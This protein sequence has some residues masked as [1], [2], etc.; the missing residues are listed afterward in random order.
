MRRFWRKQEG[1]TLVELMAVVAIIGVLAAIAVPVY[2]QATAR[3]NQRAVEANLRIIDGAIMMYQASGA[4]GAPTRTALEGTYITA[5][6]V[7]PDGVTY[8]I[9]ATKPYVAIAVKGQNTGDWFPGQPGDT[10]RLPV[11][12]P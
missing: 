6:P 11:T 5:W 4:T 3:A 9:T 8:Q 2:N 7:G 12:W 10:V 1:F